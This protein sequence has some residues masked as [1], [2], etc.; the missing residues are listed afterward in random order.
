MTT[1]ELIRAA[2]AEAEACRAM[3][4]FPHQGLDARVDVWRRA[5]AY[6]MAEA[7][8]PAAQA[9]PAPVVALPP[10]E[11]TTAAAAWNSYVA[12]R[13]RAASATIDDFGRV[14]AAFADTV[15]DLD[16]DIVAVAG[17]PAPEI[18][19]D[20]APVEEPAEPAPPPEEPASPAPGDAAADA[21]TASAAPT[22]APAPP[23]IPAETA[24]V[25]DAHQAEANPAHDPRAAA[26]A[27][28]TPERL[29]RFEVMW[30]DLTYDRK[31]IEAELAAMPGPPPPNNNTWVY[32]WAAVL[33]LPTRRTE[34]F[35]PGAP[36]PSE[37]PAAP[38][39]A[40]P[41]TNQWR[42]QE[43]LDLLET[44]WPDAALTVPQILARLNAL[45]GASIGSTPPLYKWA[46]LLG[47]PT[48]RV[49]PPAPDAPADEAQAT[50]APAPPEP[51]A[52]A[53]SPRPEPPAPTPFAAAEEPTPQQ[54]E[55]IRR[56]RSQAHD[57]AAIARRTGV[58]LDVVQA[59]DAQAE[60]AALE[61][62]SVPA[63]TDTILHE[64]GLPPDRIK[65]LRA[66]AK[67]RA[68]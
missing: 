59:L 44:L 48:Q 27:A 2:R 26:A 67:Q 16:E 10:A 3:M 40:K 31:L 41:T 64:T 63:D 11:V 61:L 20:P 58:P 55:A 25:I 9:A 53:P 42:T 18:A 46:A 22:E 56:L 21:V 51:P 17:E 39:E 30:R 24:A 36:T 49:V 62:L 65:A 32:S 28:R 14:V 13:D 57:P 6:A 4:M 5:E 12:P 33:G 19:A 38:V 37:P 8:A 45:P 35:A 1:L 52:A 60:A 23:P 54:R 68:A 29:A 50:A 15:A 47:L 66:R 7:P 43:R 34:A